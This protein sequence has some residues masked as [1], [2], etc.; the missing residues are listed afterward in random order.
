MNVRYERNTH[1]ETS[2][3]LI[4]RAGRNRST[5]TGAA[6]FGKHDFKIGEDGWEQKMCNGIDK[7]AEF[8]NIA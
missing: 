2:V 8:D 5:A 4:D 7:G 3:F 1:L 6:V